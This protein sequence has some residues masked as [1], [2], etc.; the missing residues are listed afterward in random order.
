MK[1][2]FSDISY[3]IHKYV[4][5]KLYTN[6]M[7]KN[8]LHCQVKLAKSARHLVR[9]VSGWTE[10]RRKRR[11]EKQEGRELGGGR[12]AGKGR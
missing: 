7:Y 3:I 1:D 6:I 2:I 8:S 4:I 9:N 5:H 10:K 11:K 12:K